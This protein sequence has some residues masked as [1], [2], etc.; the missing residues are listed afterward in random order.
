MAVSPPP[1]GPRKAPTSSHPAPGR[2]ASAG[3]RELADCQRTAVRGAG[4]R[5]SAS[6]IACALLQRSIRLSS[7]SSHL[8]RRVSNMN[9]PRRQGPRITSRS[10][11]SRQ[12]GQSVTDPSRLVDYSG[13]VCAH[14]RSVSTASSKSLPYVRWQDLSTRRCTPEKVGLSSFSS[15]S[16]CGRSRGSWQRKY[17][18]TQDS[19]SGSKNVSLRMFTSHEAVVCPRRVPYELAVRATGATYTRTLLE[20]AAQ[21]QSYQ[22]AN[23]LCA[24][25]HM[26]FVLDEAVKTGAS[27]ASKCLQLLQ[28]LTDVPYPD[29]WIR[30]QMYRFAEESYLLDFMFEIVLKGMDRLQM[31]DFY[32]I[33]LLLRDL[34][35]T[36]PSLGRFSMQLMSQW[37]ALA[38]RLIKHDSESVMEFGASFDSLI[39]ISQRGW[40]SDQVKST[41]KE[42]VDTYV[43]QIRHSQKQM[44]TSELVI[45]CNVLAALSHHAEHT[46]CQNA[47][48][49][50]SEDQIFDQN[51]YEGCLPA[52][53][54]QLKQSL[55]DPG[56]RQDSSGRMRESLANLKI[57]TIC[58]W[59]EPDE[60]FFRCALR[61][62]SSH[63]E[64]EDA[65][66]TCANITEPWTLDTRM[67]ALLSLH[68]LAVSWNRSG[69]ES[70][71]IHDVADVLRKRCN[72]SHAN[73]M[74]LL[75]YLGSYRY[76]ERF[77]AESLA[78]MILDCFQRYAEV[79]TPP[80]L[81]KAYLNTSKL[82]LL[83]S[84]K[85][86][87]D[88]LFR[89]LYFQVLSRSEDFLRCGLLLSPLVLA[90]IIGAFADSRLV[91]PS[92]AQLSMWTRRTVQFLYAVELEPFDHNL[93]IHILEH[94]AFIVQRFAKSSLGL[95]PESWLLFVRGHWSLY[96]E[97]LPGFLDRLQPQDM[98]SILESFRRAGVTMRLSLLKRIQH[99][100]EDRGQRV[101]TVSNKL[102]LQLV[103]KL[104]RQR[105]ALSEECGL[106]LQ[107]RLKASLARLVC[108]SPPSEQQA[109]GLS[110]VQHGGAVKVFM[111]ILYVL[112]FQ[113]WAPDSEL[114]VLIHRVFA[115]LCA[116]D[117]DASPV[118]RDYFR[119]CLVFASFCLPSAFSSGCGLPG[120]IREHLESANERAV[121]EMNA[122]KAEITLLSSETLGLQCSPTLKAALLSKASMFA[123]YKRYVHAHGSTKGSESTLM[124]RKREQ[125]QA[126]LDRD[127]VMSNFV[128]DATVHEFVLYIFDVESLLLEEHYREKPRAVIVFV[129]HKA[130]MRDSNRRVKPHVVFRLKAKLLEQH[131]GCPVLLLSQFSWLRQGR[132]CSRKSWLKDAL[133]RILQPGAGTLCV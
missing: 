111:P 124:G 107:K 128:W 58:H 133:E 39:R 9:V 45:C 50:G 12:D 129:P 18:A 36:E 14:V 37:I 42:I 17:H 33:P 99:M 69:A 54:L 74:R 4:S 97:R 2:C 110:K 41:C 122:K 57:E 91:S 106:A 132:L 100:L 87:P 7:R 49:G 77:C 6:D 112:A 72:H 51:A 19:S 40:V 16:K 98:L 93:L 73:G 44:R 118:A 85:S 104:S 131:H 78:H 81:L 115:I 68:G 15:S 127:H 95:M 55:L 38:Q 21:M 47:G 75:E 71:M 94:Y 61:T 113:G 43:G 53:F 26:I 84:T 34:A 25:Q 64:E 86:K 123:G 83:V 20:L 88:L 116:Q 101:D 108:I 32:C 76:M 24:C 82:M 119:C 23:P 103:Q 22:W 10:S 1:G 114:T 105:F 35:F 11:I 46:A 28:A 29:S 125:I 56:A 120:Y 102:H 63:F 90:E 67:D 92:P 30:Q 79:M 96:G 52:C 70:R 27:D 8:S 31:H 5:S 60:E 80:V 121:E 126:Q 109:D 66:S 65:D 89:E 13:R 59:T 62:L 130:C 48:R 3:K 117:A